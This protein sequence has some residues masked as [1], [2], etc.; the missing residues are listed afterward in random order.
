MQTSHE[1]FSGLRQFE[2]AVTADPAIH[3]EEGRRVPFGWNSFAVAPSSSVY[4]SWSEARLSIVDTGRPICLRITAAADVWENVRLEI[5][6]PHTGSVAAETEI[7]FADVF[8][9]IDIPLSAVDADLAIR[10]GLSLK[11]VHGQHPLWLFGGEREAGGG[12]PAFAPQLIV[13]DHSPEH[14][15]FE[16][17]KRQFGSLTSLQQFSWKEGC[18]LDG[19]A[20][21]AEAF[22]EKN[23]YT[24]A[25]ENHLKLFFD[26]RG[27]LRYEDP[28][29]FIV[30]GTIY[31]IEATLPFA[32]IA[33]YWPDHPSLDLMVDYYSRTMSADGSL[34][35]DDTLSAEGAYTIAYPLAVFAKVRRSPDIEAWA[36]K[37][38]EIRQQRLTVDSDLYLRH[39]DAGVY[40][41][42]N[43]IRAYTW[44][45]LGFVRTLS[46]LSDRTDVDH[47]KR[48]FV[49]VAKIALSYQRDDGLWHCFVDEP[50]VRP[51]TSGSAGIA[52]ALAI[53]VNCG[54]LPEYI[55]SRANQTLMTLKRQ[56]ISGDG[57]LSGVSQANKDGEQLQR[58]D[59]RIY[60]QMGMG[61]T[62]Q[63]AAALAE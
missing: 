24:A 36:I 22:P 16:R 33:R 53:G 35:D 47:L 3:I 40:T 1:S 15:R 17:F 42:R 39:T 12:H 8:Q 20:D 26:H 49:R 57:I 60:S 43:W 9:M 46:V 25:I 11:M 59:Y 23:L 5:F 62:A 32:A 38:L 61:L 27:Q 45:L 54:L 52:A 56:Y 50:D 51:D 2:A 58:S 55:R 63:L 21:M 13:Y 31:G 6:V 37:Q 14:V 30:D 4:L 44:Y 10:H 28:W 19:L 34:Y 48:E 29:T 41:F 7:R 18:V